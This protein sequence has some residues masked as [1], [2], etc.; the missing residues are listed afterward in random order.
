MN[1]DV[2]CVFIKYFFT[3]GVR[4]MLGDFKLSIMQNR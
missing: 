1:L 4:L 2:M 3:V